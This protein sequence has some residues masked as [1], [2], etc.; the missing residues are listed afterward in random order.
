VWRGDKEVE[1]AGKS[2]ATVRVIA[3]LMSRG[4]SGGWD[5]TVT[6]DWNGSFMSR[7]EPSGRDLKSN[8]KGAWCMLAPLL[9]LPSILHAILEPHHPTI[10]E[11]GKMDGCLP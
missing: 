9:L 6:M 10:P 4:R 8:Q 5:R 7:A 2:R 11:K 1:G 3:S